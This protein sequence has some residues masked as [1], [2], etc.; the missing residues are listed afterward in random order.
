M[1]DL[2]KEI[3]ETSNMMKWMWLTQWSISED[4]IADNFWNV[5]RE[6]WEE[7]NGIERNL[8][9]YHKW[10]EKWEFDIIAAN[11]TKVFIWE[12][13]TKLTKKHIDKL[14][15]ISIPHFKKYDNRHVWMKVYGVV[16]TRVFFNDEVKE[17]AIKKWLYVIKEKHN[18]NAEILKESIAWVKSF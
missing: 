13:K 2:K 8:K 5:F 15:D 6:I 11:G 4:I 7:I 9:I 1:E 3:K 12:T 10:R 16:W 18:W 14:V 17:Y